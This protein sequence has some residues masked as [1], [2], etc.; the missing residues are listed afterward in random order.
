MELEPDAP[1]PFPDSSFDLA[2]V[3]ETI[4]HVRDV[5]LFVSELRRVLLPG[6]GLAL[7]TPAHGRRTGLILPPRDSSAASTR[8]RRTCASS[9]AAP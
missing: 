3:A 6:G 4:E 9:P 5:Q 8:S 1:L 2:L 7:T